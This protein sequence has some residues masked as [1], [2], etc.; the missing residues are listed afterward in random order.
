[1][2]NKTIYYLTLIPLAIIVGLIVWIF[3]IIFEGGKPGLTVEPLPEF[4]SKKQ[5]FVVKA[6]DARRG[7]RAV[8]VSYAGG[9]KE[10]TILDEQFSFEGILNG[11]G[12]HAYEKEFVIDT[13]G[14]QIT[15][16]AINITIQAWDYSRKNGGD[17]N[18]AVISHSM[19]LDTL[20]PTISPLSQM[21]NINQGGT[22]LVVYKTSSD[23]SESGVYV[24]DLFFKGYPATNDHN[25]EMHVAY[26]AIPYDITKTPSIK[27]WA[28][29]KAGNT[30]A[31]TFSFLVKRIRFKTDDINLSDSF[32]QK[33]CSY[34]SEEIDPNAGDLDNYL[35][36]NKEFRLKDNALIF[37]LMK[38]VSPDKLWEGSWLCLKN[39][40]NK[41]RYADHRR[42]LYNGKLVDEQDHLGI[43][44]AS[45]ANDPIEAENN[46]KVL[47]AE[48]NGIYGN[49]VLID[50]GQG[51]ASLYGHLNDILVT[52]GQDVKKGDIIG[53]TGQTGL[54]GGDHL[55]VSILVQGIFVNPIE[56]WDDHWIQDNVT[57]KLDLIKSQQ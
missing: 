8:K 57:S 15:Q 38:D 13:Q 20:P 51:I 3:T 23:T 11:K 19:I 12:T 52:K 41:A 25:S 17:G 55:H 49:M 53:H 46:G 29:D 54:A 7:L 18:T 43:D 42:Y 33:V 37:D 24:D 40:E 6:A 26:F 50:H 22:G 32:L 21:H 36:I 34:F 31:T 14:L 16:G 45:I 47:F 39:A 2:K 27:L 28:K 1:M 5:V 44:L 56:W 35:K 4:L 10:G 48:K 30:A 9:G